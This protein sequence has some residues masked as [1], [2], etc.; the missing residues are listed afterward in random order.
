MSQCIACAEAS[1]ESIDLNG[2]R[3]MRCKNCGLMWLVEAWKEAYYEEEYEGTGDA[4]KEAGRARNARDR[5]RLFGRAAPLSRVCDIG[6]GDGAFLLALADRGVG[7]EP[8]A[9]TAA[10]ARERGL[11]VQVG[12]VDD[13]PSLFVAEAVET[14]TMFHVIEHLQNPRESL[15]MLYAF[16][17]RGSYLIIEAPN[18][19]AHDLKKTG[20]KHRLVNPEHRYYFNRKNLAQLLQSIGFEIVADGVRGY[21]GASGR[22]A[23]T[24]YWLRQLF[25]RVDY[26][27]VV[28]RKPILSA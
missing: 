13:V 25:G 20:F 27:W 16:M 18:A 12:G 17:K 5:I 24:R 15:E 26:L 8:S 19:D 28:A 21:A 14:Y 23:K 9:K 22:R 1:A 3:G 2:M 4:Q 11:D 10:R 6:C 7:V